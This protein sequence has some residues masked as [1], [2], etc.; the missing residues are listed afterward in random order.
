MDPIEKEIYDA[1]IKD[2]R[3]M[4]QNVADTLG[5]KGLLPSLVRDIRRLLESYSS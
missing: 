3:D 1:E 5:T 4:L 2:Y